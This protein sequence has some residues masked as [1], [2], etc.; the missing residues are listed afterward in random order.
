MKQYSQLTLEKRYGI[1]SM[2]KIDH[3]QPMIADV[4]GVHKSAT[5]REIKRNIG[6]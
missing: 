2:L 6:Q 5:S 3:I 4:F 1:Y